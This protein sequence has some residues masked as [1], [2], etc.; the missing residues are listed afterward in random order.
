MPPPP[1]F[2][3]RPATAQAR[4]LAPPL[5]SRS[6]GR[7]RPLHACARRT[8]PD[9]V[10]CERGGRGLRRPEPCGR[11]DGREAVPAAARPG[12]QRRAEVASEPREPDASGRTGSGSGFGIVGRTLVACAAAPSASVSR[13]LRSLGRRNSAVR[14]SEPTSGFSSLGGC[15]PA[16]PGARPPPSSLR[17]EGL[18]HPCFFDL[19]QQVLK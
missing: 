12:G 7:P 2:P 15:P 6:P 14:N 4:R 9:G 1:S 16:L 8:L 19:S 11:P 5:R 13:G 3:P 10:P 18:L 17:L